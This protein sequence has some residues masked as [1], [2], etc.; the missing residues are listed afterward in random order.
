VNILIVK[1]SAIGDVVHTLP[2]LAAL[3]KRFPDAHITWVVEEAASDLVMDHPH[4]NRVIISRRKGWIGDLKGGRVS[5][6][7][8]EIKTLLSELR[9]RPYD[10]VIDFHGLFKSAVIV[11]LSGGRRKLGYDSLQELSGLFYNEKIPEDMGKHAVDRYL[12]FARHLGAQE[13]MPEFILPIQEENE[14]RVRALLAAKGIGP[15]DPFVAVSPHALWETKLWSD[16]KFAQLSERIIRELNMPVVFT[17]SEEK[18]IEGIQS[19][20]TLP[21]VDL[22]GRTTLRDLACL[23]REASVLVTTDSGPMHLAAAM[24]TPVVALFGPTDPVRTGPYGKDHT[25]IRMELTCSPCFLKTCETRQCMQGIT[26]EDVFR[27]V[28]KKVVQ[29]AQD[30]K[31]RGKAERNGRLDREGE[32]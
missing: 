25:V 3:R 20:M 7:L 10:L 11:L 27:A 19:F 12:D 1:L 14:S 4:L 16:Q 28:R 15:N 2:S 8:K 32:R 31:P 13:D 29:N 5:G 22:S 26:V 24:E 9:A 6:A 17:G 23:F 21:S 30:K 18:S